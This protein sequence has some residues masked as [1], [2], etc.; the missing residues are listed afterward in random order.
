MHMKKI[1][2]III[3]AAG[4]FLTACKKDDYIV[5]GGTHNAKVDMTTLDYLRKNPLFDTLC[6][7]IDK[8]GIQNVVNESGISFF[9]PTDYYIQ[10]LLD[11]RHKDVQA[12]DARKSY[13]VDTLIKYHLQ[14]FRDS[15]RIHIVKRSLPYSALK[16]ERQAMPTTFPGIDAEIS[17]REVK[18]EQLG[19]NPATGIYPRIVYYRIGSMETY[20]QTS[21]IITNTG[22]LFVLQN[23]GGY[24]SGNPSLYFGT[25]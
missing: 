6:L 20:C 8:A 10:K 25:N 2:G 21:G 24:E 3:I 14:G 5:G 18:S 17:Y 13:T 23:P 1:I 9:A 19:Y 12:M 7:L 11:K 16:E 22:M 4:V 15:I